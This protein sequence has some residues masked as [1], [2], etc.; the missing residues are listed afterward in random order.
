MKKILGFFLHPITISVFGLILISLL[1]WFAGPHIKFGE[2]NSAPLAEVTTRLIVIMVILVLWGLNNLRIQLKAKKNNNELVE[3][4][5]ENQA[6]LQKSAESGK[7]AEEIQQLN[8]R[9]NQALS[10][11]KNLK[12][13]GR[14]AKKALYE[15]PWYIIVGPPGS[16]KTTALVNS[17]LE[18]PLAEQFGKGAL[19]GVGGTRNCDWWFTN[20]AVLIDTAGRYTTQDSHRVVDSSAWEGFLT[21]LKRNRRRRP[22]NGAIVAISLQDLLTQTEEERI[23]HA[24]TIRL[25]LDELMEKLEI[26]FPIYL[27]FTKVD[28]VS[29]FREFFEDLGRDDRDQVWGVSLPN[30]PKPMQGPDFDYFSN[31]FN[32][33]INRLYSRVLWRVHQERNVQRRANIYGFPQQMENLKSIADAFVKQT[34]VKN[35]YKYQ[36]YLRGVYFSSGTQDG[37]PIDRLMSAI[38]ANFGFSRESSQSPSQ[39]GRSFF[40]TRLFQEVIFPESELVG[41]N[42]RYEALMRWGQRASILGLTAITILIMIAWSGSVTRNKMF[43]SDVGEYIAE[44]KEGEKRISPWNKDIR[45]VLPALNALAKASIV[46]DQDKH[47]WLSG[48]GLYDDRVDKEANLA[49]EAHLKKLFL[50]RVIQIL[51]DELDKGHEGGDLYNTFRLYMMLNKRDKFEKV[52]LVNWFTGMWDLK[53]Q[54]EATRRQELALHLDALLDL[55]LMP[56]E[57]NPRIVKQTRRSLLQVPVSQRVYARIKSNPAFMQK[58]NLLNLLGESASTTFKIDGSV[59]KSLSMPILFTIDGYENVDFSEGSELLSDVVNERWVLDDDDSERVDFIEDDLADLSKRVKDHYYADYIKQWV[60]VYKHLDVAE[61]RSLRHANDVLMSMTDPVYSPLRSALELG[62]ANTQLTP[63]VAAA[64]LAAEHGRGRVS[65]LGR[66]ANFAATNRDTTKVDKRFNE[67]HMLMQESSQGTSS[68]ETW[69]KRIQQ[70]QDFLAEISMSPDPGKKAFEIARDR[71]K[72]GSANPVAALKNYAKNAPEPLER[73]LMS[74]ADETWRVVMT[75]ASQYVNTQWHSRVYMPYADT[76]AGRYPL[77]RRTSDELA[78]FDFVEFFKPKGIIHSFHEEFIKPFVDLNNNWS[79]R[80]VDNYSIGFSSSSMSQ[81]RRGLR[82][83]DVFFRS[84]PESPTIG[85]ELKPHSMNAKHAKFILDV[86]DTR[87]TYKHGPKFWKPVSWSG[88]DEGK[89]IRIAI[90]DLNGSLHEQNFSGPWAWFRLMDAS[91]IKKTSRS[92]VYRITF[93]A[94]SRGGEHT[95]VYEGKTKSVNHPLSNSLLAAFKAPESL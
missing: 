24:K 2:N 32:Q 39:Q 91:T 5:E 29:G 64:E 47:P 59:K 80:V 73:W 27:M 10:T 74:L 58:V 42:A 12:F 40:L 20:S 94:G 8:Q 67:L 7:A 45:A 25:R 70:M 95:I 15:L 48:V 55:D 81:V 72:N 34:F 53:Y 78:L 14:G 4:L 49:Y 77:N 76:L 50:P 30:A 33:L 22:I 35:R 62:V 23:Q 65:R 16:G 69:V 54:G 61:F 85:V 38:S 3:D 6:E 51:E 13:S 18:F 63:P 84:N 57:L 37:T 56:I 43:M 19:Q 68:F 89:R 82:I 90:E 60:R 83:K 36:P 88:D 28:L 86:A 92:N 21:L 9:F 26:R 31:E 1:V 41:S 87:V 44:F 79:N 11:L 52:L 75:T 71:Y 93:S 66:L 17:G 46:Y